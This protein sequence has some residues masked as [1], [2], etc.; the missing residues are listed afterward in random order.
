MADAAAAAEREIARAERREKYRRLG[1]SV[2]HDAHRANL[3]TNAAYRDAVEILAFEAEHP[4][5]SGGKSELIRRKFHCTEARYYSRLYHL[6]HDDAERALAID[7]VTVHRLL[8]REQA[9]AAAR[10][11]RLRGVT[12]D[13]PP[14]DLPA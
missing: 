12:H 9:G 1:A 5:P 13:E 8:R 6:I 14:R 11:Q 2:L 3:Q 10:V 4:D 7:A